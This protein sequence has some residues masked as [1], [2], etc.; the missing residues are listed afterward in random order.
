MNTRKES[1]KKWSVRGK[2]KIVMIV[3]RR[4]AKTVTFP[5]YKVREV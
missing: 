4:K 2:T 5:L 3:K 1:R